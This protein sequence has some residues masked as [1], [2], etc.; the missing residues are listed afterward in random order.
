MNVE[1]SNVALIVTV[2]YPVAVIVNWLAILVLVVLI[3]VGTKEE[4][5]ELDQWI[6]VSKVSVGDVFLLKLWNLVLI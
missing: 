4:K 5:L 6:F 3:N 2:H 1:Y